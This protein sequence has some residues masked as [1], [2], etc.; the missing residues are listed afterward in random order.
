MPIRHSRTAEVNIKYFTLSFIKHTR[1]SNSRRQRTRAKGLVWNL[2]RLAK[3]AS[4][5]RSWASRRARCVV[6]A[7]SPQLWHPGAATECQQYRSAPWYN[8]SASSSRA[9]ATAPEVCQEGAV[10]RGDWQ[11]ATTKEHWRKSSGSLAGRI[12]ERSVTKSGSAFECW[13]S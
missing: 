10:L 3:L 6:F 5:W 4:R 11:V 1:Y 13:S 8:W 7:L 9:T 12:S 2:G